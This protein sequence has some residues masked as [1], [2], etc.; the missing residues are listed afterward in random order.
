MIVN[1]SIYFYKMRGKKVEEPQFATV[2]SIREALNL[3]SIEI[4]VL[5][6]KQS[7]Q[8]LPSFSS[9]TKKML[10]IKT[11]QECIANSIKTIDANIKAIV[12]KEKR[13]SSSIQMYF[14]NMLK[15]LV[16]LHRTIQRESLSKNEIYDEC[17]TQ[18]TMMPTENAMKLTVNRTAQIRQS[19]F[20]LTNTLLELKLT[21]KDQSMTLDRID[22][23]FDKSNFYLEE[24][25]QEID[26]IPSNYVA[27]KDFTIYFLLYIIG[28]L[29]IFVLI[30]LHRGK[31]Q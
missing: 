4:A 11:H 6:K 31:D 1:R 27:L 5:Q 26:K 18:E 14:T 25:N 13:I 28:V 2:D 10:E 20:N 16:V 17:Q 22:F 24:A 29:L 23:F 15:K 9:R 12:F 3:L 21:L 7:R 19:I 30:K 8:A